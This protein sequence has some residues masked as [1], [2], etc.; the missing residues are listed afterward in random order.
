MHV[1]VSASLWLVFTQRRLL[2]QVL[3]AAGKEALAEMAAARLIYLMPAA[4][5]KDFTYL[6][7]LCICHC[8]P[9]LESRIIGSARLGTG[10]MGCE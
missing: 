9:F 1:R 2:L 10:E 5:G 6:Y 4:S 7:L 8:A 3:N